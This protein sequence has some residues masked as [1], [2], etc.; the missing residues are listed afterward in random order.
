VTLRAECKE[1]IRATALFDFNLE[2][3]ARATDFILDLTFVTYAKKSVLHNS[4]PPKNYF[5]VVFPKMYVLKRKSTFDIV[6]I[7]YLCKICK[8]ASKQRNS[9]LKCIKR[10]ISLGH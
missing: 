3:V 8:E 5:F 1:E 4:N 2:H 7:P 9:I 6:I 10:V